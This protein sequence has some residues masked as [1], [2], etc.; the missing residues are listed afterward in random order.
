MVA[1]QTLNFSIG[2][3]QLNYELAFYFCKCFEQGSEPMVDEIIKHKILPV[4][5]E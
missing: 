3:T 4:H 2:I 1:L 5:L